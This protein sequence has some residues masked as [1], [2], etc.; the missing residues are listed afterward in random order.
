MD[1]AERASPP[2]SGASIADV[3]GAAGLYFLFLGLVQLLWVE[4]AGISSQT[5]GALLTL[6][7][8]GGYAGASRLLGPGK[9]GAPRGPVTARTLGG[10]SWVLML[11][12]LMEFGRAHHLP[13]S[14]LSTLA[15][16]LSALY[17][18]QALDSGLLALAG[19]YLVHVALGTWLGL[20]LG[21][22]GGML[23]AHIFLC[24]ALALVMVLVG[25]QR[26]RRGARTS[27]M[28]LSG[29][30]A[31]YALLG[32][33]ILSR[34]GGAYH[35]LPDASWIS[36][37]YLVLL[38]ALGLAMV[39]AGRSSRSGALT[40]CG[41]L[42]LYFRAVLA[43]LEYSQ[44]TTG[45]GI[46][47]SLGILLVVLAFGSEARDPSMDPLPQPSVACRL[48]G[49]RV[50]QGIA[51][52][53]LL[54]TLVRGTLN[55]SATR[56]EVRVPVESY[57]LPRF[58]AVELDPGLIEIPRDAGVGERLDVYLQAWKI[59]EHEPLLRM[60]RCIATHRGQGKPPA[61]DASRTFKAS[62]HLVRVRL[63]DGNLIEGVV[64]SMRY[65]Y[66]LPPGLAEQPRAGRDLIFAEGRLGFP[67]P[68]RLE[69]AP[70]PAP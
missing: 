66:E 46:Y 47:I 34:I 17:A 44:S 58:L 8:V 49:L 42:A 56:R 62:G 25:L 43:Y 18:G 11:L 55:R 31:A 13:P 7:T 69:K 40:A 12:G 24:V 5:R 9:D 61:L 52:L 59:D 27:G 67:Y 23:T 2:S 1:E 38:V 4:L 51:A 19:A 70:A 65:L 3:L 60:G 16:G 48:G 54:A 30:G 64:P 35:G 10:F 68:A 20:A 15:M 53:L 28:A 63:F 6:L 29:Y 39:A 45:T 32:L 41:A 57:T 21:Q 33:F 37:G 22:V 36:R 26:T 14:D 50:A